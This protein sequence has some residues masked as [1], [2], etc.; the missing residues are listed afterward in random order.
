MSNQQK[1]EVKHLSDIV[2]KSDSPANL[3]TGVVKAATGRHI[4]EPT[5][6]AILLSTGISVPVLKDGKVVTIL[7]QPFKFKD[8]EKVI[9]ATAPIYSQISGNL[10]S[11]REL[12]LGMV[13]DTPKFLEF[14]KEHKKTII[15]F[16][17]AFNGELTP[18]FVNEL[19]IDGVA[20][21]LLTIVTVN[22]DFFIQE[23]SPKLQEQMRDLVLNVI[24][25]LTG[26]LT[27]S[28]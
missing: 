28:Q 26:R 16:M 1:P 6:H 27:D 20:D 25:K 24:P 22:I 19:H 21:L 10:A 8:L 13:K 14:I 18:S 4:N 23:A 5:E 12:F 3:P 9:S 17:E 2:L 11:T 7:I 15:V